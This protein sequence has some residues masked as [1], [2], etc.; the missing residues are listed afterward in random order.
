M[1]TER[2]RLQ[3]MCINFIV[4]YFHIPLCSILKK[5]GAS[6]ARS[7]VLRQPTVVDNATKQYATTAYSQGLYTK[8]KQP[9]T[10][11]FN[12]ECDIYYNGA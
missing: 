4:C 9:V 6:V 8:N 2:R 3:K 7:M 11:V 5:V 1:T 10:L 12:V